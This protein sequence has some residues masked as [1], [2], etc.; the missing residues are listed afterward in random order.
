M[1]KKKTKSNKPKEKG[2][3][4]HLSQVTHQKQDN[5]WESLSESERK[6]F[7]PFMINRF[8]SM[9]MDYVT[10]VSEI[11]NYELSPE[12][13]ERF[14][15]DLLPKQKLWNKYLKGSGKQDN[16]SID[17][18]A[19]HLEVSKREATMYYNTL[20]SNGELDKVKEIKKLYGQRFE[21]S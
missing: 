14:Y 1:P 16:Q 2:L 5:Y 4:D 9:E 17:I 15:R 13:M 21:Q 6:S 11:Q 10:L 3:F 8:L 20:K 19:E 7:S 18:L 12:M